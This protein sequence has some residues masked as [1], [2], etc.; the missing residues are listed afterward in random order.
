MYI[1]PTHFQGLKFKITTFPIHDYVTHSS[2]HFYTFQS[3]NI[4]LGVAVIA[5]GLNYQNFGIF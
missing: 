1:L 4:I 5:K 2:N 3:D